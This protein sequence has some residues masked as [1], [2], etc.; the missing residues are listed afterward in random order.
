[1]AP[2]LYAV[3][4]PLMLKLKAPNNRLHSG[5]GTPPR[6]FRVS[7]DPDR[8]APLRKV[9]GYLSRGGKLPGGFAWYLL[10]GEAATKQEIDSGAWAV[11]LPS[12]FDY[13]NDGDVVRVGAYRFFFNAMR[14]TTRSCSPSGVTTIA[15]CV[16]SH[17]ETL[18]MGGSWT[19]LWLLFPSLAARRPKFCLLVE[20]LPY[21]TEGLW[22]WSGNPSRFCRRQACTY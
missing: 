15:L 20:S 17:R 6:V 4:E 16:P 7:I 18:R 1:D 5:S 3:G 11:R 22:T 10:L 14:G 13:L 19:T 12:D 21:W 8:P 2:H 9:E